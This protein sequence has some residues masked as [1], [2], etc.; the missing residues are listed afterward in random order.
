MRL[1]AVP[2]RVS[3]IQMVLYCATI[4]VA[5]FIAKSKSKRN[6]PFFISNSILVP[7]QY[8]ASE[9]MN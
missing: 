3:G 2:E 7:P 4:L 8:R 5:G 9:L 6:N 1:K